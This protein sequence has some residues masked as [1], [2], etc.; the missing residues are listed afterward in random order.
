MTAS[1][2]NKNLISADL[3]KAK[4]EESFN[5]TIDRFDSERE[6][7][8]KVGQAEVID[9]INRLFDGENDVPEDT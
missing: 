7:W 2:L 5:T 9:F 8:L 1:Q 3:L 4:L 6:V